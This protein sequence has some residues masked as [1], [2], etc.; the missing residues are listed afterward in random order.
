MLPRKE[1]QPKTKDKLRKMGERIPEGSIGIPKTRNPIID[2]NKLFWSKRLELGR[3]ATTFFYG[4]C[5]CFWNAVAFPEL[6]IEQ[7]PCVNASYF[8]E[9]YITF[10]I[11]FNESSISCHIIITISCSILI[12][13]EYCLMIIMLYLHV[14]CDKVWDK[15][16]LI[17]V[18]CSIISYLLK[19][20]Y[21]PISFEPNNKWGYKYYSF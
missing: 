12:I 8:N 5:K 17:N 4:H 6:K 14:Y 10:I 9:Q 18:F 1:I 3:A 15:H 20:N 11:K 16:R 13:L 7:L 2:T 21:Q 19:S